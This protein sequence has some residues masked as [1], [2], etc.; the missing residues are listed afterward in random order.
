MF[1]G[2]IYNQGILKKISVNKKGKSI[3]IS[4]RLNL[5]KKNVGMSIACDGVCLT[6]VSIKRNILE[7]NLSQETINKSKFKYFKI[8]DLIETQGHLGNV[9]EIQIFVTIL[10]TPENKTVIIPNGPISNSDIINYTMQGKIRVDLKMGISYNS[11]IKEA[12]NVLMK[13]MEGH[14]LILKDPA[15]FVGVLE[16]GDSSVNL[17]VR[18]YTSPENYWK[19][20]FDIYEKGKEVLDA[21]KIEIP[22]PQVDLNLKK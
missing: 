9:K 17:A 16:L 12:R 8:G 4:C 7:F 19:V 22:F 20:Y 13:E 10:L 6:L 1:N 21:A 11:N 14:P 3:F 15:P 2:I 5:N 18:P